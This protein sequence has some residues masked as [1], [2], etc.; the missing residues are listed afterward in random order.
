MTVLA[1]CV[2]RVAGGGHGPGAHLYS[3]NIYFLTRSKQLL[4][5]MKLF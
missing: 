1:V 2:L 4:K 3:Q 5:K